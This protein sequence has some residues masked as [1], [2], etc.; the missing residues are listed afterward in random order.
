MKYKPLP[1]RAVILHY[2]NYDSATGLFTWNNHDNRPSYV[3]RVAG[4]QGD[5]YVRLKLLETFY[6][7]HRIAWYLMTGLDPEQLFI[8]H[9]DRDK[10]NNAFNNL[11][12][13][14]NSVNQFNRKKQAGITVTKAGAYK[15]SLCV[16]GTKYHL[17]Y[18]TEYWNALCARKAGEFKYGYL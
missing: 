12:L 11:R 13:A 3:G 1:S 9:I 10:H 2:Y 5:R 15:V 4:S 14:T 6:T 18:Y 16:L 7:A 8:D 17:G